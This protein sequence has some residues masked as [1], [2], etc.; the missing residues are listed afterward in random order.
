MEMARRGFAAIHMQIRAI[1]TDS[2]TVL[3]WI[4]SK[5]QQYKVFVGTRIAE[6]Q[7]LVGADNWRYVPSE[8]NPADNI[9][10]GKSLADLVKPNHWTCGLAFLHQP[11][12]EWP[13][14]PAVPVP[15]LHQLKKPMTTSSESQM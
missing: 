12:A 14:N 9:T 8:E 5:S 15:H 2:M 4:Q 6:I 11:P 10:C 3:H 7:E 13:T 1:R